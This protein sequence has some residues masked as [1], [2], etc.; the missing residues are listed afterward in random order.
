MSKTIYLFRHSEP[1]PDSDLPSQ[2]IPL[3]YEG[4]KKIAGMVQRFD[5]IAAVYSSPYLRAA[6]TADAFSKDFRTDARLRER[7]LGRPE[8]FTKKFWEMQYTDRALKFSGGESFYE[9]GRRMQSV[10]G[11]ILSSMRD[12]QSVA[13]ISHAA[14]IC[15]YLMEFPTCQ[16]TVTDAETKARKILWNGTRLYEGPIPTPS[17]FVLTFDRDVLT[18]LD[19]HAR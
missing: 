6:Q 10:M 18:D 17:Y 9:A 8:A 13:V 11:E 14:A 3:S 4:R 1:V 7:A 12:G 2:E 5:R 16:I 19:F 15:A